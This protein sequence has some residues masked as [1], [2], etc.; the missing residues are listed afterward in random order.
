[1]KRRLIHDI[2]RQHFLPQMGLIT[3]MDL[4]ITLRKEF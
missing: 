1:M 4:L 3:R 2:C